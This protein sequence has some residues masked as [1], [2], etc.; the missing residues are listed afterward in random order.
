MHGKLKPTFIPDDAVAEIVRQKL[1]VVH[2]RS[3]DAEVEGQGWD[4]VCPACGSDLWAP[5]MKGMI[6]CG[7]CGAL[8]GF[9][10]SAI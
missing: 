9:A 2:K 3:N 10:D 4:V 8:M 1:L 7:D 6:V 5:S